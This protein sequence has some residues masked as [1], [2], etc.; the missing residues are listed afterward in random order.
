M[1]VAVALPADRAETQMEQPALKRGQSFIAEKTQT[2]DEWFGQKRIGYFAGI[3]LLINN[4][5]GPGVPQLPNMFIE[6]GWLFPT[7]TILAIW[8]MTSLST[9]M[10]AEAMRKIPGNEHF[11]GRLEYT[12]IVDYYFGRRAYIASQIGLNG[13]LQSLNI[14]SVIQSAQVMDN[15]IAAI[16]GNTCAFDITP[17][18]IDATGD[19]GS[20]SAGVGF[21]GALPQS[22]EFWSCI[23]TGGAPQFVTVG[24]GDPWGCHVVVTMGFIVTFLITLPMGYFN[25]DDNMII[26]VIA[27]ILTILCWFVWVIAAFQSPAFD[28]GSWTGLDPA[29]MAANPNAT[30]SIPMIQTA[31]CAANGGCASQAGV[32]GTVLF[33]FGFVTTVPSW[34]NEKRSD[35][36]V[37]KTVW[38]SS[39]CCNI[40]FFAIGISGCMAFGPYLAGVASNNCYGFADPSKCSQ[41]I[42]GILTN[43]AAVNPLPAHWVGSGFLHSLVQLS[44]YL[45][46][47]VAILSSIPV[48][49]IVIKYRPNSVGLLLLSFPPC[50]MN[51]CVSL[52]IC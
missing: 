39:F 20:G 24:Q 28:G 8:A 31:D 6:S 49:S 15:A 12:S 32:L 19:G 14:I 33:N 38:F 29:Y 27:F 35:V 50:P 44:V 47:P 25:L 4:I 26:Q 22:T 16:W 45:F 41:S 43:A 30:W 46:P 42:L 52:W 18:T 9:V 10:Y 3:A 5:T 11:R 13:A 34:I 51:I 48:F 37:N 36:S 1:A 7:V 21:T 23:D 2:H 17:F 40:V